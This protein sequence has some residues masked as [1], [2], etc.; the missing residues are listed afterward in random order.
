[1]QEGHLCHGLDVT[2]QSQKQPDVKVFTVSMLHS[3]L[4]SLFTNNILSIE[5]VGGMVQD[6][7]GK[8]GGDMQRDEEIGKPKN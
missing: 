4:D 7:T 3:R 2:A 1:M 5:N 6:S 8:I